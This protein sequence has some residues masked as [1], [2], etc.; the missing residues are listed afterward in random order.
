[1]DARAVP[2]RLLID[3]NGP[4]VAVAHRE[5]AVDHSIADAAGAGAATLP[6]AGRAR[7]LRAR[8][9][10]GHEIRAPGVAV[11]GSDRFLEIVV[12]TIETLP[13]GVRVVE[14]EVQILV[15]IDDAWRGGHRDVAGWFTA[16][17]VVELVPGVGR[18]R[19]IAVGVPLERALLLLVEPDSGRALALQ[20]VDDLVVDVLDRC[21]RSHGRYLADVRI[22]EAL[23]AVEVDEQA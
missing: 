19:E 14:D 20:D 10:V 13:E 9:H 12:F 3:P 21:Q 11:V 16:G 1:M 23:G 2:M 7:P 4:R 5:R 8:Q 6:P 15:G 22:V 17:Q 18:Y